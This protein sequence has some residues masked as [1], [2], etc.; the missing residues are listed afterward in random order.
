MGR[1]SS[2]VQ[3]AFQNFEG[4]TASILRKRQE[5]QRSFLVPRSQRK[6][7]RVDLRPS[8]EIE[9]ELQRKRRQILRERGETEETSSRKPLL[10]TRAKGGIRGEAIAPVCGRRHGLALIACLEEL[11]V[12][13]SPLTVDAA[14]L[15]LYEEQ[16]EVEGE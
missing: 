6:P 10:R 11:G 14:T 15:K 12:R 16:G 8:A 13:I 1:R 4:R 3:N 5:D 7:T 9:K 2:R